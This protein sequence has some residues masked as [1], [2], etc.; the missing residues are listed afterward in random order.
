MATQREIKNQVSENIDILITISNG[1][2]EQVKI[3]K[4]SLQPINIVSDF[5]QTMDMEDIK[6]AINCD[7]ELLVNIRKF[8]D[9]NS[10]L[11]QVNPEV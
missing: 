6:V 10:F 7:E 5:V 9:G 4:D 2:I 1:L 8:L 3:C 11:K